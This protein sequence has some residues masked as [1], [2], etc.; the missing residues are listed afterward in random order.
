MKIMKLSNLFSYITILRP[1]NFLITFFSIYFAIIIANQSFLFSV[2]AFLGSIAGALISGAGMVIND[3]FDVEIDKIN[4]PERPIPSG[5]ISI[6]SALTYY[7]LLN[8]LALIL[9]SFTNSIAFLIA[10]LSII[11]IFLYS[12]SLKNKGLVGNFVVA[13]MTGLAFIF[14]GVIG[15]NILPLI[16][17]FLFAFLINF[18]REILKDIEDIEGDKSKNLKTFP[19]VFGE[20]KSFQ[21]ITIILIL[22]IILTIIPYLIEVFNFYYLIIILSVVDTVLIYV[23]KKINSNPSKNDLRKLSD[24]V[25][26]EMIIGLIAIYIGVR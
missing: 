21:L 20:K 10:F 9:I 12:H 3:Y 23:I 26:Y 16:F 14:G 15:E 11:I 5:K 2:K 19:I 4:R 1:I 7:L 8:L 18:A 22:T 17:P 24:L 6:K 13:F 25:K